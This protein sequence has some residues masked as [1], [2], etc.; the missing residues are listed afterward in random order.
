MFRHVP[1]CL[2]VLL[3]CHL[4][5]PAQERPLDSKR[6]DSGAAKENLLADPSFE[7]S[8]LGSHTP[9][10][11]QGFFSQPESGYTGQ[12]AEGGRTG[13]RSLAIQ[14]DGDFGVASANL[15]HLDRKQRY[16]VRGWVNIEGEET[17]AAD[18]KFHYYDAAG[19]Y[20]N[21]TRR[22]YVMPASKGWQFITVVDEADSVPEARQLGL[23]VAVTKRAKAQYDDLEL[24]AFDRD[25]LPQDFELEYGTMP[26]LRLLHRRV[27]TWDV[28]T[29]IRPCVWIPRGEK[30]TEVET[31]EWMLGRQFV[32]SVK[33]APSGKE[34]SMGLMT[35]DPRTDR[36]ASWFFD[37]S[38]FF[39]RTQSLGQW[40][41][42]EQTLSFRDEVDGIAS[43]Y[44]LRFVEHKR[45]EFSGRWKGKDGKVYL[46]IAGTAKRR[47]SR[48]PEKP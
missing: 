6:G 13:K 15:V 28:E 33:L 23:A 31:V 27:G 8:E 10:R 17:A 12:V 14:G 22:G 38:G 24:L 37:S 1:G 46:D 16:V 36:Y 26:K 20:L 44:R 18:V 30:T 34:K 29:T 45:I 9:L 11:W 5:T 2:L 35:F 4:P 43:T 7:E 19:N 21:Q 42:E 48:M 47:G 41:D 25:A 32:R 3:V 39:P 40:D